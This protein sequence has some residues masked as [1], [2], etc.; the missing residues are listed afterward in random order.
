[1]TGDALKWYSWMPQAYKEGIDFYAEAFGYEVAREWI[2]HALLERG[3][4]GMPPP[5]TAPLPSF[6]DALTAD[7]HEKQQS[8]D[9]RI[10]DAFTNAWSFGIEVRAADTPDPA[11]HTEGRISARVV[12]LRELLMAVPNEI[13]PARELLHP[14]ELAVFESLHPDLQE[15]FWTE[16]AMVYTQGLTLGRG[17]F[18]ALDETEIKDLF[19]QYIPPKEAENRKCTDHS[20]PCLNR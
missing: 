13:P 7:E 18:P 8:L 1:M 10:L 11:A 15:L 19:S 3:A 17:P 4:Y 16:A 14:N 20:K 12:E 6:N 5:L 2:D 9:R